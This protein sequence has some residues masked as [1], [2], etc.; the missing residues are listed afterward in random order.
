MYVG[1]IH[2]YCQ[3]VLSEMDARHR[4]FDV[5][6]GNR[7]KLY[8]I[9][10]YG[11]LG[12][13]SLRPRA[14]GNS[15]FDAIDQV[16]RAWMTMNDEMLSLDDVENEDPRLGNALR[17]L[18]DG[19]DHDNYIDFSLMVRLVAEA[20]ARND[21][22]AERATRRVRHLM[23]DEYQD[24]NP[25]QETLIR[26]LDRRAATLLVVGD[27]DQA[28]YGWRGADVSNILT[29]EARNPGCSVRTLAQ[30]FRST[31]AIVVAA[32]AFAAAELGATRMVKDPAAFANPAPR[33]FRNLWFATRTEEAQ[34]VAA[35]VA[36]LLGSR[37]VERD[38]SVRGL[39]PAD[40][41]ILMRSTRTEELDH[42]PR[43]IAYTAALQARGIS[44]TLEAGG[45]VFDRPEVQT[46]RGTF[47]LLRAGSPDRTVARQFFDSDVLPRY[48]E[49]SFTDFAAVLA[50]WGRRLHAPT[51]G[52]RRRVYPQQ[53]VHDLLAAFGLARTAL[54]AGVMHDLGLFS[55]MMQDVET[56]YLS[57][58]SADR[59][60]A[61]CNFLQH[62]ADSGYDTG[63]DDVLRRPDTVS[64]STVHQV[65][66]LEF[67][68]VFVVDVEAQRFPRR[69]DAYDGWLP[70]N[71]MA[72]G[73]ARG[74][75]QST[76]AEEARLFYTAL[77]RAERFLYVTGS[78]QLPAGRRPRQPS[79]FAQRLAHAELSTNPAAPIAGL[80]AEPARRRIDETVVPT[81]FSEI[82]YYLRCPADFR[83]R[84]IFGFSPP[85]T[86][87]FGYGRSVHAAVGKLHERYPDAPPTPEQADAIGRDIFHLKLMSLRAGIPR[88]IRPVR[89][90]RA[91]VPADFSGH[92]RVATART[93]RTRGSWSCGS[94][95]PWNGRSFP[96]R[97]TCCF[98]RTPSTMSSMPR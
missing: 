30:N 28:I 9:S 92:T 58:D 93:S 25:A 80:V 34:W 76:A 90:A 26:E 49:A 75:Y 81:S 45:S 84:S 68:V 47:E 94:R 61:I 56:V 54:D 52:P 33:D 96:A 86:E 29:F 70:A 7:L 27:D 13:A 5:L 15:Y 22:G 73:L 41:A 19:L 50:D 8:L 10:R 51:D 14:R 87:M 65:K 89:G 43:H 77:T 21:P 6:D 82:R 4:Q 78:A 46:L 63:T 83:F 74:A 17:R 44:F 2:A 36:E 1:T 97:S 32:D 35:R 98:A 18:R 40:F 57:I 79:A 59:F 60:G 95:F 20:L 85:I 48:P 42:A 66:G 16:A 72:A 11:G 71:L 62:V 31:D 12:I 39:T 3:G 67:P 38:G 88:I 24:V 91:T 69:R 64:V 23:V 53:L 55:R 37:Y